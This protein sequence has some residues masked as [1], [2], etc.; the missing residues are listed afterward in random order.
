[1][2]MIDQNREL[3][4]SFSSQPGPGQ[5][6]AIN[7]EGMAVKIPE[8]VSV[9]IAWKFVFPLTAASAKEDTMSMTD[10]AWQEAPNHGGTFSLMSHPQWKS[11]E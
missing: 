1:M 2:E 7:L 5:R 10:L 11:K 4:W 8:V 6:W 9:E 3:L